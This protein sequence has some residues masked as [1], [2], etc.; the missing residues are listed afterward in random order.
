MVF[1]CNLY[2]RGLSTR[3]VIVLDMIDQ[4][5][6]IK[7]PN[8]LDFPL[9]PWKGWGSIWGGPHPMAAPSQMQMPN[10][11]GR[12]QYP[13]AMPSQLWVLRSESF[14]PDN[15]SSRECGHAED[16]MHT[17]QTQKTFHRAEK[18]GKMPNM[19][20]RLRKPTGWLAA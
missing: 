5:S 6:R 18:N 13:V 15:S 3:R 11:N 10:N 1:T 2:R 7:T 14:N 16:S 8:L 4:L 17:T 9:L 20:T 19:C 12:A